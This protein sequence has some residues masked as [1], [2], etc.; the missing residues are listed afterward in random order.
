[1]LNAASRTALYAALVWAPLAPDAGWALALL[2]L[3]VVLALAAWL[4][5]T[6]AA[7]RLEWRR[8]TLDLPLG[9]LVLLALVQLALGN[10]PLVRWALAPPPAVPALVADVP[11]PWLAVGTVKPAQTL[12]SFLLLVLYAAVYA[13]VVQHV[14]TRRQVSRLVRTLLVTGGL[15]ALLGLCD[16]FAGETWLRAWRVHPDRG[17][18]AATFVDPNHFAAWLNMLIVLGLGWVVARGREAREAPSVAELLAS[19]TLRAE[20]VRRYLPMLGVVTMALALVFTLSRGGVASLGA[21]LLGLILL[22][23]ALGRARR[24]SLVAGALLV[25]ALSYGSWI[26]VGPF[27]ARSG[28]PAEG[29]LADGGQHVAAASALRDF[30]ALG[31]GLGAWGEVASR[32]RPLGHASARNDLLRFVVE[33]GAL[34]AVLGAFFLWRLVADLVRVHLFGR[35]ACPVD[36]GAAEAARRNDPYSV[37]IAIGALAGAFSVLVHS[38]VDVPLRIPA[39]GVLAATL[40]GLAT[41]A[42][43]TRLVG[44]REQLLT[45]VVDVELGGRRAVAAGALALAGFTALAGWG[46]FAAWTALARAPLERV[47]RVTSAAD[48]GP[49]LALD[50][51]NE[52]ALL[53]RALGRQ[54]AAWAAWTGRAAPADPA[55]RQRTALAR[56]AEGRADLERALRVAPTNPSLH[57][58]LAVLEATDAVVAG[59]TGAAALAPPLAHVARAIALQPDE[60]RLYYSAARL[61]QTALPELGREAAREAVRRG[62]ELI[63]DLVDLYRPIGLTEQAWLGLVPETPVDRL[64]LATALEDRQLVGEGLAAYRAALA[65]APEPVRPLYRWMFALALLRAGQAAAAEAELA[66]ALKADPQNPELHRAHG[67]ARAARGAADALDSYRAALA[68]AEQRARAR[69]IP[70]PFALRD[71]RLQRIAERHAGQGWDRPSRYRRALGR[72]LVEHKLWDAAAAEWQRL[73]SDD[74]RDAEAQFAYGEAL[75]GSGHAREALER[76]RQ[77]VALDGNARHYRERLAQRLWDGEQFYRAIEE[78]RTLKSLAPASAAPRLALARAYEKLGERADALR[79]YRELLELAPENPGAREALTRLGVR[80]P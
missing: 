47:G 78:W 39:N 59:R 70:P 36:G 75:D 3:L 56:L 77:A 20:A 17:R 50:P 11:S 33:T 73:A 13:L 7:G 40:L 57:H 31:V 21:A 23:V 66:E 76:Y 15:V 34:G 46:A 28:E 27:L 65:G 52:T 24:S 62:P 53:A 4:A 18:L 12:P 2:T 51:W 25:A 58:H 1:M 26:G 16:H 5:A 22:L 64:D 41:V 60:P 54:E 8:T 49:V 61:A 10:G 30:P 80:R 72:Y 68:A 63:P 32:Y 35:G 45:A 44:G 67:Q 9:L 38:G 6:L 37:G 14:R 29:A 71:A 74:P 19:R 69:P 55:E 43:H 48:A 79:E 42:L